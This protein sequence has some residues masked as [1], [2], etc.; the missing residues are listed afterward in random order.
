MGAVMGLSLAAIVVIALEDEGVVLSIDGASPRRL[1]GRGGSDRA[2]APGREDQLDRGAAV[3]V[4]RTH[5]DRQ[6]TASATRGW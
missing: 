1:C 4:A 3:R 5:P 2:G 6:L